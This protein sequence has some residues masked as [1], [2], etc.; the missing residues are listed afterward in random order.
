MSPM[1]NPRHFVLRETWSML[2]KFLESYSTI[3]PRDVAQAHW[4]E[5]FANYAFRPWHRHRVK[6]SGH[7]LRAVHAV[8]INQPPH[9]IRTAPRPNKHLSATRVKMA[10]DPTSE[11]LH[12]R[13][14]HVAH[15]YKPTLTLPDTRK[16]QRLRWSFM[17]PPVG[18]EPTLNRF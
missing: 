9:T 7:L 12:I 4:T 16:D 5:H 8:P 14:T 3:G 15:K 2:S 18:L 13:K 1:P 11:V 17:V 10:K 6:L